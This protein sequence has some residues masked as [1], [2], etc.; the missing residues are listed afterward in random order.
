VI[1]HTILHTIEAKYRQIRNNERRYFAIFA[2]M[3]TTPFNDFL[4]IDML[5]WIQKVRERYVSKNSKKRSEAEKD[6]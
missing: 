3:P 4:I 5:E 2:Y 6:T 1:L